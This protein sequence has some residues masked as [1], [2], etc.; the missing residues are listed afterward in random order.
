[1]TYKPKRPPLDPC[2]VEA[3][4]ALVSG[5][6]KARVLLELDASAMT[7]GQLRRA[8]PGVTQQVLSTQLRGLEEDGIISRRP[9]G[10][11]PGDGSL[12]ALTEEGCTLIP[13]LDA[14]A[15]WGLARLR[16]RG[17]DWTPPAGRSRPCFE[18]A[19]P[20]PDLA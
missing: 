11:E 19:L 7:F 1:M 4:V 8:L 3:V 6:W 9:L 17:L 12:Y 2:P 18:Q 10:P 5:K 20:C 14:V 16:R 15:T 13:L